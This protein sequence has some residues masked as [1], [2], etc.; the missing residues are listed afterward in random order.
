MAYVQKD[1]S[2]SLFKNDRKEK[3][4]HPDY[5][6]TIIVDG[7]SYW[8]S[9]WVKDGAKGKFFS[10]AVKP[11]DDRARSNSAKDDLRTAHAQPQGSRASMKQEPFDD[12]IPFSPESR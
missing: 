3:D 11:K 5:S 6:G 10:L 7:V 12:D 1:N 8:L 9:A 4:T 2:G